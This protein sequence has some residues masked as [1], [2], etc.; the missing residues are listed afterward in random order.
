MILKKDILISSKLDDGKTFDEDKFICKLNIE[1]KN[2]IYVYSK[3][4][5][6]ILLIELGIEL[7][8]TL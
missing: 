2:R 4:Y 3:V 5:T 7:R 6:I 8:R 1:C